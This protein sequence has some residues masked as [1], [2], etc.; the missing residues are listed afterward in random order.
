MNLSSREIIS[1][2]NEGLLCVERPMIAAHAIRSTQI[3]YDRLFAGRATHADGKQFDLA[4]TSEE[5]VEVALPQ[6]INSDRYAPE[7]RDYV[8]VAA[9][10]VVTRFS[11]RRKA[12][13]P[14]RG[15][16]T[17]RT[18]IRRYSIIRCR[19]GCR[20]RRQRLKMAACPSTGQSRVGSART[21][22]YWWRLTGSRS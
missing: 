13:R 19:F 16:R 1:F 7:L 10:A 9:D 6:I 22:E 8:L 21:S 3:V 20:S 12:V 4:G 18:G 2:H 15:T 5:G 17:K 14:G 11:S